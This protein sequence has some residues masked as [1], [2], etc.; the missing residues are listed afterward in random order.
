[1]CIG[2]GTAL[3]ITSLAELHGLAL[4]QAACAY[5]VAMLAAQ[6]NHDAR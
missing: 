3:P 1:M 4:S 2:A 5:A 6:E